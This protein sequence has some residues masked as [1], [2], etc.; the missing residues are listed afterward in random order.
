MRIG[1]VGCVKQKAL[2]AAPVAIPKLFTEPAPLVDAV[3]SNNT[4]G[5]NGSSSCQLQPAAPN[6]ARRWGGHNHGGDATSHGRRLS[7]RRYHL[8]RAKPC[9]HPVDDRPDHLRLRLDGD[10][11]T[12]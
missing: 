2:V 6:D 11:A 5:G 8:L 9:G 10:C 3:R 1:L 12:T 7:P 4:N